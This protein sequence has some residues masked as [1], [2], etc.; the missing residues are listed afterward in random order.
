[1]N[2][3]LWRR[4]MPGLLFWAEYISEEL[5]NTLPRDRLEY[6]N[7]LCKQTQTIYMFMDAIPRWC[8]IY[9]RIVRMSNINSW[10]VLIVPKY[11]RVVD[12]GGPGKGHEVP[13]QQN[14]G[15]SMCPNSFF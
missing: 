9:V 3:L 10:I 5:G 1:M 8:Y 4:Q 11:N 7:E 6:S 12:G 14:D 2:K 13:F 15:A